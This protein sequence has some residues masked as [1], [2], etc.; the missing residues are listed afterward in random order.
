MMLSGVI[1][2][3]NLSFSVVKG[4][5]EGLFHELGVKR[6]QFK[7]GESATADIFVNGNK[8]GEIEILDRSL[9][10][11]EMNF[12]ALLKYVSLRKTFTPLPKFPEAYEDLRLIIDQA[13]E[14]ENIV[15]T[16]KDSSKLVTSVK[17]L[18]TY[19]D[20]K[21]FRITFQSKEKNLTSQDISE[22]RGKI[23]QSLKNALNAEIA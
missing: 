6:Y 19:E 22:A 4:I 1:K 15:S 8:I 2:K 11:F 12:T 10:D 9:I 3:E 13:V 20:K 23:L 16:I 21:T 18:D 7:T 17:L 14:F 5:I